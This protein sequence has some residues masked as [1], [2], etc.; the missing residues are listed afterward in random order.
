MPAARSAR[1]VL[2]ALALFALGA[3]AL[4]WLRSAAA[5]PAVYREWPS[6][7]CRA[8]LVDRTPGHCGHLPPVHHTVWVGEEW[9]G[10]PR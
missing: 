7:R 1:T 4:G 9:G 3:C 8:V 10:L 2:L 6:R 5:T